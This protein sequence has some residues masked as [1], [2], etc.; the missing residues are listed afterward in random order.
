MLEILTYLA[1]NHSSVA[2]LLFRFDSSL[3]PESIN[4]I[5]HDKKADKGKEKVVEGEKSHVVGS[6]SDI[7]ILSFIKL[8][9]QPLFLHSI[10]H[11]EQVL[12]LLEVTL[13]TNIW[14]LMLL[15]LTFNVIYICGAGYGSSSSG[16][17][18]C[19]FKAGKP[20]SHR[21]SSR[22]FSRSTW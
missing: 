10:A 14:A 4:L 19:G 18:Q 17:I 5:H 3:V 8:L 20:N 15:G 16:C 11:L 21:T 7:P 1:T 22:Q 2:S 9:N 13:L 6:E 12:F